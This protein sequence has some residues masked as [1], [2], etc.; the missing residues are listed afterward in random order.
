VAA[1]WLMLPASSLALNYRGASM[2][3]HDFGRLYG[4]TLLN[5]LRREAVLLVGTDSAYSIPMYMKW[6]RGRRP[7]VSVLSVNRLSHQSYRE[8]AMR[9]ALDLAFLAPKDYAEA[10]SQYASSVVGTNGGVYGSHKIARINGYLAGKLFQRN[11][12]KRPMYYDEGMPIEWIRDFAVPSGLVMELKEE[13]IQSLP[14]KVVASDTDYWNS[15]EV[16]LLGNRNFLADLAARQKFS[17]CRS[18]AGALYLHR[19]MYPE[20][21]AALKQA[22]RFSDRN[23]E[24]YAL[25]ALMYKEQGRQEEAVRIFEGYLRRDTWNTSAHAFARSLRQ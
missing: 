3:G 10:F 21:E 15:L 22:I 23:I 6:V 12:S 14:A 17:K 16:K 24:A 11:I 1:L 20:A 9:N 4:D 13:R 7:D 19:K 5:S 8:E 25:L 18:N 2:R